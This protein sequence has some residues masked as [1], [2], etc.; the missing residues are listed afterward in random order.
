MAP[1]SSII[2]GKWQMTESENFDKFMAAVG[3]S[4]VVRKLGNASK[5]LV[6]TVKN[7]LRVHTS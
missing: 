6:R 4:Y 5:P 1:W 2:P 7:G 3:V